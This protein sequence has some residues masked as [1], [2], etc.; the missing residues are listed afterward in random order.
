MHAS[1]VKK[2]R[3]ENLKVQMGQLVSIV[4]GRKE[5]QLRSDTE[6][7][8]KEQVN[9]ITLKNGK[10][11]GEKPLKEQ[12][13][14]TPDQ[15]KE[16]PKEETKGSPLKLNLDTIPP[17]IP[18][19]KR[20]LKANLDK[21]FGKFLEILKKIH[22]NILLIDALSQMPSYAKFL[23]EVISNKRKWEN[24][25]TVKLNEECSTIL[26]NKLP[27]KLRTPGVFR[28]LAL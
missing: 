11:L 7:N 2:R 16:E 18:Y 13:E 19:P 21:Q 23:K 10:T 9:A 24:G 12:V 27:P 3:C 26:Q 20:V 15:R 14:E 22:V 6:K 17:Y 5:G 25:E 4:A 1:K 28:S 8:P